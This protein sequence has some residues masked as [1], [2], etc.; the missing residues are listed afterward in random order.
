[1][2]FD[3][4]GNFKYFIKILK[5]SGLWFP[6]PGVYRRQ[7][8]I[9]FGLLLHFFLTA[10]HAIYCSWKTYEANAIPLIC[11]LFIL[12]NTIVKYL[13]F[14]MRNQLIQKCIESV[15][16]EQF[17]RV[18][19]VEKAF[20]EQINK[21]FLKMCLRTV[22]P[23]FLASFVMIFH[24]IIPNVD[25][26]LTWKVLLGNIDRDQHPIFFYVMWIYLSVALLLHI[27]S[28]HAIDLTQLFCMNFA[29]VQFYFIAFRLHL[30]SIRDEKFEEKLIRYIKHH[31]AVTQYCEKLAEA[32]SITNFFQMS[33]GSFILC[34]CA[35]H[36]SKVR[37]IC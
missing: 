14:M 17:Q 12:V 9:I 16:D 31:Q 36:L 22:G 6:K 7:H 5:I 25:T 13:N 4:L 26:S 18:L 10:L 8:Y 21:S 35:F 1:M 27:A 37:N 20:A 33:F 32:F 30:L 15:D 2:K 34:F 3:Y 24:P 29:S 28:M 19:W 23:P 11:V